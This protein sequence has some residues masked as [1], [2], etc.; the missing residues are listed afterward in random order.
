MNR[1]ELALDKPS[2]VIVINNSFLVAIEK[3]CI[4]LYRIH[5]E[6]LILK[7]F[8]SVGIGSQFIVVELQHLKYKGQDYLLVF[9]N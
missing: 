5:N 8:D 4:T 7:D 3:I 1:V 6:N 2:K 9:G